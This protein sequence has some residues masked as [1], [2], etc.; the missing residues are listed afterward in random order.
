[1]HACVYSK[2]AQLTES[3]KVIFQTQTPVCANCITKQMVGWIFTQ[4]HIHSRDYCQ[5]SCEWRRHEI[6]HQ[7]YTAWRLV[8]GPSSPATCRVAENAHET[9]RAYYR[10]ASKPGSAQTT[11]RS[12]GPAVKALLLPTNNNRLSMSTNIKFSSNIT[13]SVGCLFE[14]LHG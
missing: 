3:N 6:R 2:N 12:P 11:A 8:V 5:H 14:S 13:A 4:G 1:M 9:L 10:S 7:C